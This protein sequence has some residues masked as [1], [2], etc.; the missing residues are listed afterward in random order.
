MS[1]WTYNAAGDNGLQGLSPYNS[2]YN[3]VAGD[4]GQCAETGNT[5]QVEV[6]A[7]GVK[8]IEISP[9]GADWTSQRMTGLAPRLIRWV[10]QIVAITEADLN[11]IEAGIEQYLYDGRSYRLTDGTRYSDHVVMDGRGTRRVGRRQ[12][13]SDGTRYLQRWAVTFKVL[14]PDFGATAF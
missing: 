13:L 7:P 3:G 14:W 1:T 5:L 12:V 4:L 8:G 2:A 11:K 10:W 9:P 6:G